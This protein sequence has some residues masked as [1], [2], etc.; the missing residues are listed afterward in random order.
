MHTFKWKWFS[1]QPHVNAL[2]QFMVSLIGFF[3]K[4]IP[5]IIGVKKNTLSI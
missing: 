4:K 5:K 2:L 3:N 1:K